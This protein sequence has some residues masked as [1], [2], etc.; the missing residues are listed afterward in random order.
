MAET[1]D[2]VYRVVLRR[3]RWVKSRTRNRSTGI[4]ITEEVWLKDQSTGPGLS[5]NKGM[6]VCGNAIE[7]S[8]SRAPRKG[9]V[10]SFDKQVVEFTTVFERY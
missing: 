2:F 7:S 6:T 1:K 9:D 5:S 4:S 3:R 10:G 8:D